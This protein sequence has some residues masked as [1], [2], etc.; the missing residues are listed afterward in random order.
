MVGETAEREYEDARQKLRDIHDCCE[1]AT[2]SVRRTI[3]FAFEC[4]GATGENKGISMVTCSFQI[5]KLA[6]PFGNVPDGQ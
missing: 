4:T 1:D 2:L 3:A 5:W 6:C